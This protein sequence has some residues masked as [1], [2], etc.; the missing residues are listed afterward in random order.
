MEE[1]DRSIVKGFKIISILLFFNLLWSSVGCQANTTLLRK[2][3]S[4]LSARKNGEDNFVVTYPCIFACWENIIPGVSTENDVIQTIEQLEQDGVVSQFRQLNIGNYSFDL[5]PGRRGDIVI[6][7]NGYVKWIVLYI[8]GANYSVSQVVDSLG[9]PEGYAPIHQPIPANLPCSAEDEI[10]YTG[11]T[12]PGYLMYPSQ[13]ISYLIVQL[14]VINSKICPYTE[15]QAIFYY[16][17]QSISDALLDDHSPV[18]GF[19]QFDEDD[20]IPWHGYG[21]GY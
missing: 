15:V 12:R 19:N 7:K 4:V 14:P 2:S 9:E 3:V 11:P 5:H 6:A 17:P 10:A 18:F 8:D 21:S 13:G 1:L 20:I 16:S